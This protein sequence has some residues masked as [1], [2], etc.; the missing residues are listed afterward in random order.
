MS[1]YRVY[2]YT[3][4]RSNAKLTSDLERLDGLY[5]FVCY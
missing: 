4:M 1:T 2:T 5:I 3:A